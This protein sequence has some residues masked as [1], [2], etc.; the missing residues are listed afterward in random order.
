MHLYDEAPLEFP[1]R[2]GR[3]NQDSQLVADEVKIMA[4][5]V[6]SGKHFHTEQRFSLFLTLTDAKEHERL[7]ED[8]VEPGTFL[9]P[10]HIGLG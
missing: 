10:I 7:F 5:I 1:K 3:K 4:S 8:F 6:K 9:K 2:K